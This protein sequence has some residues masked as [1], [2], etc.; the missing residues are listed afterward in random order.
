MGLPPMRA[1]GLPGKRIEAKRAGIVARVCKENYELKIMNY[2]LNT[3]HHF[4]GAI[5][6]PTAF[7]KASNS[8]S[9]F[10]LERVPG[11][12][13]FLSICLS[14]GIRLFFLPF[15]IALYFKVSGS[16]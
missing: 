5:S 2:E 4:F 13:Y 3:R 11:F 10:S 1:R 12:P 14:H 8:L 9:C 6:A 16:K 7:L 15:F